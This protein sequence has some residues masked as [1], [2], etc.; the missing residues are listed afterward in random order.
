MQNHYAYTVLLIIPIISMGSYLAFK[1][2]QYNYFEH[3]ILNSFIAGQRTAIFLIALPIT[4]FITDEQMNQNINTFKVYFAIF[5]TFWVYYKF[6]D[7]TSPIKRILL[8]MLSYLI[9]VL[10]FGVLMFGAVTLTDIL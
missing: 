5:L 10:I 9:M 2:S 6:F 3:L 7:Y 1:K 8:I 4:Y